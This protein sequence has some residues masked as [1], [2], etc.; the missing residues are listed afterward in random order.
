MEKEDSALIT[1]IAFVLYIAASAVSTIEILSWFGKSIPMWGNVI[2][3][4]FAGDLVIPVA[5][6]GHI[7][8]M[9]GVV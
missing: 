7:L 9:F 4:L 5:V 8:R 6:V 1:L 3:G 2:I